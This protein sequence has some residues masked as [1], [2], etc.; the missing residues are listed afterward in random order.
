MT[1]IIIF[2]SWGG[3]VRAVLEKWMSA[4]RPEMVPEVVKVGKHL[5]AL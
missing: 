2:H 3:K 5:S 1:K 4:K